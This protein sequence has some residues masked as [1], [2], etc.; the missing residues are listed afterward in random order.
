MSSEETPKEIPTPRGSGCSKYHYQLYLSWKHQT[1]QVQ[2]FPVVDFKT[3][4]VVGMTGPSCPPCPLCKKE[5][6]Y[7]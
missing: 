4:E 6:N 3:G 5:I 1:G 7:E 2:T